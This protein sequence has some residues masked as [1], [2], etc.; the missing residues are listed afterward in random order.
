MQIRVKNRIAGLIILSFTLLFILNTASAENG[1]PAQ[2]TAPP[3]GDSSNCGTGVQNITE[4]QVQN[5]AMQLEWLP[6]NPPAEISPGENR[7]VAA[8]GGLA[9]YTWELIGSGVSLV[10]GTLTDKP[11][12]QIKAECTATGSIEVELHSAKIDNQENPID[13]ISGTINVSSA[14]FIFDY[15]S[16][17]TA[18]IARNS[19]KIIYVKGGGPPYTWIVNESGFY[20]D[21]DHTVQQVTTQIN[22]ALLYADE[23]ACGTATITT[24]DRC[25]N[26]TIGSIRSSNGRYIDNG[27]VARVSSRDKC[28]S[29]SCP[30]HYGYADV[31]VG[32]DN[33]YKYRAGWCTRSSGSSSGPVCSDAPQPICVWPGNACELTVTDGI[34]TYTQNT[35]SSGGIAYLYINRYEWVCE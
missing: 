4:N 21:A 25:N 33:R 26:S 28:W 1:T 23:T 24:V 6:N 14:R 3:N 29:E 32:V 5:T 17:G 12:N 30:Q 10:E 31:C 35:K 34:C 27:I 9:S 2:E 18:T 8:T 19:S 7:S 13:K 20:F 16:S 15:E 11:L 22:S